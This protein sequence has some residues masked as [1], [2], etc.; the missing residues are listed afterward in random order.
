MTMK[1]LKFVWT[2]LAC[3]PLLL[4][5][6]TVVVA[7]AV[8]R[9]PVA[10][11]SLYSRDS[12]RFRSVITNEQGRATV[13]FTF[14]RLTV[15]HLNYERRT[16][17]RLSDTI[18]LT[19]K[20]QTTAEV[21][22]TNKEPEW[23][24][25]KLRQVVRQKEQLYQSAGDTLRFDYQTQ[26][27]GRDNLY[28]YQLT[29]LLRTR[30]KGQSQYTFLPQEGSIEA[31]D[32]TRL[33]DTNN[34]RRMLYEDFVDE[35]DGGFIRSHRWGENPEYQ[36]NSADEIEL[37][38][39][40]KSHDDDRGR[41]VID[42]ARCIIL[43]ASRI[44]G[45][46]TNKAERMPALLYAMARVMS[47]YHVEKW[48]RDY[49]VSYGVRP[50]GTLYQQ[51]VR[52]KCYFTGSETSTDEREEE[53][54]DQT[55]GGFPNMEATLKTKREAPPS[56]PEGATIQLYLEASSGAVEGITSFQSLPPSWYIR[57][58]S[59]SERQREIELSNLPATFK[60]FDEQ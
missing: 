7:D 16:V 8:T 4:S 1:Q 31:V 43:Q 42:T 50:D 41:L 28:H 18:L 57:L 5:A 9:E 40:S 21:V 19:P 51:E 52:Y 27:I 39:R 44:T 2:A 12:G 47:G 25:R 59:D 34:L 22:V 53:Y 54:R 13:D 37:I 56:A 49:R 14:R 11:A 6:Q 36:G 45:T 58:S 30:H 32:S 55:G 23:I 15:S 60:L 33:T 3:W 38:F 24:R 29:G 46:K 35:L 20:Y 48:T 26:S 17:N 10:H